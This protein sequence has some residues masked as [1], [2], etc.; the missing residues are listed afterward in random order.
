MMRSICVLGLALGAAASLSGANLIETLTP[1]DVIPGVGEA[2]LVRDD[3]RP[4]LVLRGT[5]PGTDRKGNH[6]LDCR[7]RLAEPVSLEGK[8]LRLTVRTTTPG[9]IRGFY[10][11]AFNLDEKAPAW[12]FQRWLDTLVR[13]D[14]TVLHLTAGR[15]RLMLWEDNVVNGQPAAKIGFLQFHLG[16][17]D[18]NVAMALEVLGVEI[19]PELPLKDDPWVAG[20]SAMVLDR[21]DLGAVCALPRST[22]LVADGVCGFDILH[23][24]S[25]AGRAAAQSVA[26]AVQEATGVAPAVR[27]GT[28]ADGLPERHCVM[29]G[30]IGS[31]PALMVAYTRQFTM[32]DGYLPG[33]GGCILQTIVE[34]FRRGADL[35]VVGASDAAG[36]AK[37]AA[38][39]VAQVRALGRQGQLEL[40]ILFAPEYAAADLRAP[41]FA[42]NHVED[43]LR[44]AQRALD[45]GRHTSLGGVLASIGERYR[46][47][48]NAADATLYAAVAKMYLASASSDPRKFGGP[49]GFDSDFRSHAAIA[50]W[51][52][53]EHDP[54]LSDEERLVTSQMILRWLNEAIVAEASGGLK[55]NG[56]VSNHLTF[57]SLGTMMG[58]FYF[59]KYYPEIRAPEMWQHIVTH[60]FGRQNR[61][62]K[63][64][65]DCNGYQWL[66]W[67]H[68]LVHAMATPDD[69]FFSSGTA[70]TVL[71]TLGLTMDNL[72]AQAPYG[73]ASGWASSGSEMI[74]L[75]MA[76]AA[77]RDPL[78][79]YLLN[80]KSERIPSRRPGRFWLPV[81]AEVP[82]ALD[83]VIVMP[84]DES[85]FRTVRQEGNNPPLERCVDKASFRAR[86]DPSALYVLIDGVNNGGH[87]HA[88]GNSLL[89]YSQY[90]RNWLMENEYI[91][92][93]QKYHNSLLMLVDGEAFALPDYMELMGSGETAEY[94]WMSLRARDYGPADWTRHLIWVKADEALLVLDELRAKADR[95]FRLRQR[96]NGLGET[97][98]CADG[99]RLEQQGPALRVQCAG[100]QGVT[101]RVDESLGN[102]WESYP[103]AKPL[104]HVL[105]N[106]FEG[107]LA[108]GEAVVLAALWHGAAD[109]RVSPW[110]L[111]GAGAAWRV[112]TGRR[113]HVVRWQDGVLEVTAAATAGVPGEPAAYV[114]PASTTAGEPA[115]VL[116]REQRLCG[117]GRVDYKVG[118]RP[119]GL[120]PVPFNLTAPE[121]R[122][123]F[124]WVLSG[125]EPSARNV[126]ATHLANQLPAAADGRGTGTENSVM[127]QADEA[128]TLDLAFPVSCR[129]S[130]VR[131]KLWWASKT[132]KQ[133]AYRLDSAEVLL[134]ADGRP[135]G[136]R[137]VV[138]HDASG[139]TH[140][141]FGS[142][143]V[144][145]LSLGDQEAKAIRIALRPQ[146]GTAI[147][148]NE[149]EVIGSPSAGADWPS[150]RSAFTK[151]TLARA[152]GETVLAVGS[153]SGDV[154]QYSPDGRVLR[155]FTVGVPVHDLA[156]L[157]LDGDGTDELL[158]ACDD[159]RLRA[160]R[161]DGTAVWTSTFEFYRRRAI[162]TVVRCVDLDGDGRPEIVAGCD[163]WRVYALDR[164]GKALWNFEVVHPTRIVEVGDIDGDGT[165]ELLCGTQY[166]W[167]TVLSADGRKLW[168]GGFGRGCRALHSVA[169]GDG[170]RNV[171]A[172]ADDGKLHVYEPGGQSLAVFDTGDA[173]RMVSPV[174]V[175][176]ATGREDFLVASNNGYVYRFAASGERL[177]SRALSDSAMVVR[178]QADGTCWVGAGD[179]SVVRL[180]ADGAV[181]A[182]ARL[183]G[184]VADLR[185]LADGAV[186]AISSEGD[187][188]VL[189]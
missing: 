1:T 149:I 170:K 122:P 141:D 16:T 77:T 94:G 134:S 107:A 174:A 28:P 163:N 36:L 6:Y 161:L 18:R 156:A 17:P 102:G 78:A 175:P 138:R 105:D 154:V 4:R 83:G 103:Y 52:L 110:A 95:T 23:P 155:C 92:N 80:L 132:S 51:D 42:A 46:L 62:G 180:A 14:E 98:P 66:T 24:D 71:K 22:R 166:F 176:G 39:F 91:K 150:L 89:R 61:S 100:G 67:H 82:T 104:A 97:T 86:L 87:R 76:Y 127:Y 53:V 143:V 147:Y 79:G 55:G 139:E 11:R 74:V 20:T 70:A 3:G 117:D 85:Y 54:V 57:A 50:G 72:G 56:V 151:A 13:E 167:M 19:I 44:D 179:G 158:L 60:N 142:P 31:N 187:V 136:F 177:W 133:T 9:A 34:P 93:Q 64:H 26:Q 128:V 84:L 185:V 169:R 135:E 108:A 160:V 49:W 109:G 114:S 32:V 8:T 184:A 120:Q 7:I 69:T 172:G 152:G 189:R 41:T 129:L 81:E 38:A 65:D 159:S 37:A 63:A 121:H 137:P 178:G 130:E 25:E 186:L 116:W 75:Q 43:G 47:W 73:D 188:A 131:L 33:P 145:A 124:P 29:L 119:A 125:T 126:F 118:A 5:T 144:T 165:P 111:S 173:V 30:D 162:C 171:V 123:F 106:G 153:Q 115:T 40:P 146:A 10:V 59:G 15:S 113:A 58:A 148:I 164:A 35:V 157:D 90:G 27:V 112:D 168:G 181:L 68:V 99:M 12:S 140:P 45:E 183:S 48:G 101:I 2:V 88:D 96:W 21:P 182:S